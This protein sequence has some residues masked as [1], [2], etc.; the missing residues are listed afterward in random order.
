MGDM[1][2][3]QILG[4]FLTN[5][6]VI[7]TWDLAQAAGISVELDPELVEDAYNSL[8]RVD[9][10]IRQPNIFGPKVEPPADA[11]PTTKLM[12]FAGRQ[13]AAS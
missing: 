9:A 12:C 10:M 7:H 3:D 1:P 11:D 2:L 6:L 8:V 13:A 4:M 5:D